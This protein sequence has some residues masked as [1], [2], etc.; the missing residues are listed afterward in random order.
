METLRFGERQMSLY[1]L[2][3]FSLMIN[4]VHILIRP[5]AAVSKITQSIK[6]YSAR[7]A[8]VI[9]GRTGQPFWRDESYDHWV[10]DNDERE[11]IIRYIEH[12]PVTVGL[13]SR[14]EDWPWSSAYVK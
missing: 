7:R 12:N 4:H 3:A 13:V 2:L 11:R 1:R 9:L 8:N 14:P 10:R 6:G 5:N